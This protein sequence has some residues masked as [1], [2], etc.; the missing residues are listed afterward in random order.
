LRWSV[1]F[2]QFRVCCSPTVP[3]T[4][5]P[6]PG[7]LKKWGHVPPCHMKSAPLIDDRCPTD[8]NRQRWNVVDVYLWPVHKQPLREE[9]IGAIC[10]EALR[11]L[12]YLHSCGFIHRDVKAG[13]VLLTENAA[14][15]L[16]ES[17]SSFCRVRKFVCVD[18]VIT[19]LK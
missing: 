7:H 4:V 11:G 3:L 19:K 9:E 13:N 1:Q 12:E 10:S 6:V 5:P 14:V 2:G 18:L 16:G 8:R 17:P 15:K